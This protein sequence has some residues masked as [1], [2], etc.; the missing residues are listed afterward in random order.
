MALAHR[1]WLD[2]DRD[3][4]SPRSDPLFLALRPNLSGVRDRDVRLLPARQAP[5]F[6][7]P[8]DHNDE[9]GRPG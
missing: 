7:E 3:L 6:L 8:V 5:Q 1:E 9:S 2:N 4:D